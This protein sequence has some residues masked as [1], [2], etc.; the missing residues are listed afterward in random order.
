M[1]EEFNVPMN[2][3]GGLYS[4]RVLGTSEP[5]TRNSFFSTLKIQELPSLLFRQMPFIQ[6]YLLPG[7]KSFQR[8][9]K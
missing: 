7:Q 6:A 5:V 1:V 3:Y 2:I 4:S 9:Y 8:A